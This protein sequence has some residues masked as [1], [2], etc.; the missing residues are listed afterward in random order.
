MRFFWNNIKYLCTGCAIGIEWRMFVLKFFL[1]KMKLRREIKIVAF[2][3]E[4]VFM[5][6][7]DCHT[8]VALFSKFD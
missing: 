7:I 4:Q 3:V 5:I 6:K 2:A 8:N 1:I